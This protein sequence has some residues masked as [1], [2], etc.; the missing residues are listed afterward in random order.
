MGTVNIACPNPTLIV[1][2]SGTSVL[3]SCIHW[4]S[5]L[6]LY[7][8]LIAQDLFVFVVTCHSYHLARMRLKR[9]S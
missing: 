7:I 4:L 9:Y 3:F 6:N 2:M 1:S 5:W 8:S